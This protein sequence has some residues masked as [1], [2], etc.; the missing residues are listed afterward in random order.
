MS[1]Y[2]SE[3]EPNTLNRV[4]GLNSG[5]ALGGGSILNF[6]GWLRADAADYD[7]WAEIVG[8]E[9]WSYDGFKPCFCKTERFYSSGTEA[10][11]DVLGFDGPM[12][13][14]LISVA[15]S[16]QRKYL[17][18][19]PVK[20]AWTEL[21]VPFNPQREKGSITGITEFCGSHPIRLILSA[22]MKS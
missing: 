10:D 22:M 20:Q 4:H 11:T 21:G 6:G 15:E 8:H 13:V 14:V 12:H 17:L 5:K 7:D 18:R 1:I 16:G 2:Q 19:D 9:R 3:F